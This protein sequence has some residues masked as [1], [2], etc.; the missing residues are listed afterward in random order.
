MNSASQPRR[1]LIRPTVERL[2]DRH[3][4]SGGYVQVNLASDVPGGGGQVGNWTG[5]RPNDAG[6]L[7]QLGMMNR[8][9]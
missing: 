1:R 4:L 6:E 7:V 5:V 9:G 2:E 8:G 3:L